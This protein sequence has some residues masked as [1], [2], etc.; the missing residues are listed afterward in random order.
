MKQKRAKQVIAKLQAIHDEGV[1]LVAEV[2]ALNAAG[3]IAFDDP[4]IKRMNELSALADKR[5]KVAEKINASR[6]WN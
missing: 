6:R 2:S 4:R 5:N 3:Q 1:A